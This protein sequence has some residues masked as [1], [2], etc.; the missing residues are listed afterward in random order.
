MAGRT[1][2]VV[3]I[4]TP[5]WLALH[6]IWYCWVALAG[7]LVLTG[8][9][10]AYLH[11]RIGREIHVRAL[12]AQLLDANGRLEHQTAELAEANL[13][14][15][16]EAAERRRAEGVLRVA[17]EFQRN[18]R[19][20]APLALV[21]LDVDRF[22]AVNDTYGHGFG[23]RVLVEVA[24][25][26]KADAR[27]ADVVA[28][29]GGEEFMVLMPDTLLADAALAAERIRLR[30]AEHPISDGVQTVRVT[31]SLGLA[32]LRAH[33]AGTPDELIRLV[34]EALYAAKQSGRNCIRKAGETH[35]P[36]PV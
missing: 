14:L 8:F 4:A 2:Q 20:G 12:A 27:A 6:R 16:R 9:A 7:G 29:Y 18:L 28:R 13:G 32:G 26:L 17:R 3:C 11:M 34:D 36:Q 15:Q 24:R 35:A 1:W 33:G 30:V 31:V 10:S 5:E 23:D 25:L 21:M 22:K 19:Q